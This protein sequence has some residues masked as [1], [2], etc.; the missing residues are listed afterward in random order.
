MHPAAQTEA[1]KPYLQGIVQVASGLVKGLLGGMC[2]V[3]HSFQTVDIFQT[4]SPLFLLLLP[5]LSQFL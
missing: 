2:G 4:T 5:Y 3:T 1:W